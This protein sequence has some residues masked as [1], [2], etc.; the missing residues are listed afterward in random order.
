MPL[1][2]GSLSLG[3]FRSILPSLPGKRTRKLA[4]LD[5]AVWGHVRNA[6][7]RRSYDD[8]L[9]AMSRGRRCSSLSNVLDGTITAYS[10]SRFRFADNASSPYILY[11]IRSFYSKFSHPPTPN[12]HPP[13]VVTRRRVIQYCTYGR[14]AV[15][16]AR[17]P[18]NRLILMVR[19]TRDPT[20]GR[21]RRT[22]FETCNFRPVRTAND[23]R[24]PRNCRQASVLGTS[25]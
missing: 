12:I 18:T 14:I 19:F 3:S 15:P 22:E 10:S 25:A 9:T 21:R 16:P 5:R 2:N 7:N 6:P 23:S 24:V 20:T 11:T 1:F 4:V 8:L 17:R 13:V